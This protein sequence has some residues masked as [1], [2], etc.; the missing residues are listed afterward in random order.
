MKLCFLFLFCFSSLLVFGQDLPIKD[1]KVFYEKI[2]SANGTKNELY[3]RAKLW[4]A[5]T[6]KDSKS[7][8]QIDNKEDGQ[9]LGK[10][11]FDVPYRYVVNTVAQCNF[12]IKFDFKDNKYRVQIYNINYQWQ[13]SG[14]TTMNIEQLQTSYNGRYYNKIAPPTDT[15]IKSM[16]ASLQKTLSS[17]EQ[18]S[19]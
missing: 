14:N 16:I 18:Q 4:F 1:G 6:F 19:F 11:N 13:L 9:L 5:N 3:N 12:T 2:D 17:N 7:V 8:I 15:Q 10:G